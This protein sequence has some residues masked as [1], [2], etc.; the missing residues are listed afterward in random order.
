VVELFVEHTK[1]GQ[2]E[3]VTEGTFVYVAVDKDRKP[4][5]VKG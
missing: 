3:K 4:I 2:E 1:T 5:K